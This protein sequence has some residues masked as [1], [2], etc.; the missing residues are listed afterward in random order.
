MRAVVD[1][2]R[3]SPLGRRGY[4]PVFP[5]SYAR[6]PLG[7]V[8][9]RSVDDVFV[10]IQIDNMEALAVVEEIAS[11]EG[12]D[13]LVIGPTDLSDSLG[14]RG[15]FEHPTVTAAIDR[16]V[17][18]ARGQGLSVGAGVGDAAHAVAMIRRGAQWIQLSGA[19]ALMWRHF[20]QLTND[21]RLELATVGQA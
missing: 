4:G 13:A 14:L 21:V 7:V 3:Y 18:A 11:I 1:N 17:A 12:I 16:I 15:N 2:C 19:D 10:A 9:D 8:A 6:L 5:S 20:E